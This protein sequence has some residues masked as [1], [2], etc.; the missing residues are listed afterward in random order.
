VG[1]QWWGSKGAWVWEYTDP[2]DGLRKTKVTHWR[3]KTKRDER[4]CEDSFYEYM[5]LLDR[6]AMGLEVRTQNPKGWTLAEAAEWWL[7]QRGEPRAD[8][9]YIR[10][11]LL[12][13]PFAHRLLEH[14]KPSDVTPW[15]TS[16]GRSYAP[17]TVN[18]ARMYVHR[19]YRDLGEH[20]LYTG[21]SP[22]AGTKKRKVPP[23]SKPTLA[24]HEVRP[25]LAELA[26]KP[27]TGQQWEEMAAC[28]LYTGARK[29]EVFAL[30]AADVQRDGIG[31]VSKTGIPRWV[32]THEEFRPYLD[33]ALARC[34]G[35]G[36]LW[37]GRG[38]KLR[39]AESPAADRITKACE[40]A[41]I[42]RVTFHELRH[43]WQSAC[44][45]SGVA[46]AAIDAM[47]W[48]GRSGSVRTDT[49]RHLTDHFLAR[50]L[51]N[52]SYPEMQPGKVVS[53]RSPTIP[54]LRS[55]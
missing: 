49:Y 12:H 34:K 18:H 1:V 14:I 39:N 4:D 30:T 22:A 3:R 33:R 20:G 40:D 44:E 41:G 26:K 27:R 23:T 17:Q 43:T 28:A 7:E 8:R 24:A 11:H 38:G 35:K 13:A 46:G 5:R 52:L 29:G 2:L 45:M 25:L 42:T 31:L 50:E 53:L 32:P 37:P 16:L 6:Q 21:P 36:P 19:V 51:A 48:S 10:K 54:Q 47:G 9:T 15:L 55:R